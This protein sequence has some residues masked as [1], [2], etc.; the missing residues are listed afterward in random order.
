MPENCLDFTGDIDLTERM[1]QI[2]HSEFFIG[3]P[4]GLSWLSWALN[5]PTVLI[6]GFSYP[7]TEFETPYRVQNT[8]VCT[9]CWNDD[10]F[11]RGNWKW[12]PKPDK[13]ELFECTKSITPDMVMKMIDILIKNK[14]V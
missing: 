12:C 14:N 4:S 10:L 11:D 7:Y 6:S 3:L 13:K 8:N 2:Y 5:K 1:N 9:G